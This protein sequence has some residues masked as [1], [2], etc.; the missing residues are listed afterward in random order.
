MST[1]SLPLL[2]CSQIIATQQWD[3]LLEADASDPLFTV[4]LRSAILDDHFNCIGL[5]SG[6]LVIEML[7]QGIG[8]IRIG[9]C[10]WEWL[11]T[12]ATGDLPPPEEG[13]DQNTT[14]A[15]QESGM[16]SRAK[17]I[18]DT[19]LCWFTKPTIT[20]IFERLDPYYTL[21]DWMPVFIL[22]QLANEAIHIQETHTKHT[23]TSPKRSPQRSKVAQA[24]HKSET[25]HS[26]LPN[27]C[28][29]KLGLILGPSPDLNRLPRNIDKILYD[30]L[31]S[32]R[33]AKIIAQI[34]KVTDIHILAILSTH[35]AARLAIEV[36]PL[37]KT[38]TLLRDALTPDSLLLLSMYHMEHPKFQTLL[39]KWPTSM[40]ILGR[41][42]AATYANYVWS[43]SYLD[44]TEWGRNMLMNL[45][46][47]WRDNFK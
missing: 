2:D 12:W 23:T 44:T 34:P 38:S 6:E 15:E 20:P 17:Y 8:G 39:E 45:C 9:H 24:K 31:H 10:A 4:A 19:L 40:S 36:H 32:H 37:A 28:T 42:T 7:I 1:F 46:P 3:L 33:F 22:E 18:V 41:Q 16:P 13:E 5:C 27:L 21:L 29:C 11:R 30:I 26:S 35:P 43:L 25:D 14:N 47:R